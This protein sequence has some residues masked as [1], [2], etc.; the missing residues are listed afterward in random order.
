VKIDVG[1]TLVLRRYLVGALLVGGLVACAPVPADPPATS[2]ITFRNSSANI[3]ATTRFDP[4]RFAGDWHVV[5]RFV[6][7]GETAAHDVIAVTYQR[8]KDRIVIVASEG[9]QTYAYDGTAVLRP[10]QGEP[11]IAMWVDE[12]FRT[13]VLGTPSGRVGYILDRKPNPRKGR[14]KAATEILKF[15]GWDTGRLKR[16]K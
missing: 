12:G 6:E 15:Y 7:T 9:A 2:D 1:I 4:V 16:T 14:L 13:A 10:K 8:G 5:A 11:L 3:G